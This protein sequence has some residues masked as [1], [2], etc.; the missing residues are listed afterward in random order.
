MQRVLT[1]LPDEEVKMVVLQTLQ[2]GLPSPRHAAAAAV[3]DVGVGAESALVVVAAAAVGA[4]LPFRTQV[5]A[6][7]GFGAV[8]A[9]YAAVAAALVAVAALQPCGRCSWPAGGRVTTDVAAVL[10]RARLG[11]QVVL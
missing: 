9:E 7:T 10:P 5:V 1:H 4:A 2:A 6:S 11:H 8:A 3:V